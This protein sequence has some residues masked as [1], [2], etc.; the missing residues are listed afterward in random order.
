[1]GACLLFLD[2]GFGY[3]LVKLSLFDPRAFW[4][5]YLNRSTNVRKR[6]VERN[7]RAG[8]IEIELQQFIK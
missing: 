2:S 5:W 1:M 3:N 8:E 6:I 4:S 7:G